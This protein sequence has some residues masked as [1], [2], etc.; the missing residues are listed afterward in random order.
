MTSRA[1]L[2]LA[3]STA[4]VTGATGGIGEA[5]ARALAAR[6]ARLLVSGRREAELS[7]LAED[8]GAEAIVSDLAAAEEV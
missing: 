8:L 6:G 7:R 5:I 2:G 4:L 3:G 1:R